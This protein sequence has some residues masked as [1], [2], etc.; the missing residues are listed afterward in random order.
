MAGTKKAVKTTQGLVNRPSRLSIKFT[1][2]S[3]TQ[4]HCVGACDLNDIVDSNFNFRDPG[5]L[6]RLV[7]AGLVRDPK[8]ATYGDF[9]QAGITDFQEALNTVKES[10][11]KF[12]MLPAKAR[13]YFENSP[14]KF[15]EFVSKKDTDDSVFKKGCELGLWLS[16]RQQMIINNNQRVQ[17]SQTVYNRPIAQT[18]TQLEP[19]PVQTAENAGQS[20]VSG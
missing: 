19:Q 4:Q 8:T 14:A 5:Y 9:S 12:M 11:A 3:M 7:K 20:G 6:N 13:D 18:A 1:E 2:P 10:R 17:Y 15:L 16:D